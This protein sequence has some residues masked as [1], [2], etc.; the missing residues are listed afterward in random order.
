MRSAPTPEP[1]SD[2][3]LVVVPVAPDSSAATSASGSSNPAAACSLYNLSTGS[4]D[5][6][7]QLR[8]HPRFQLLRA[9]I[10]EPLPAAVEW[11]ARWGRAAPETALQRFSI[12]RFAAD[13]DRVLR[14]VVGRP[15]A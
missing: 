2:P 10:V 7:R 4:A 3:E 12:T 1:D 13:W 15:A 14:G 8:A 6:V 11:G 9:D 5:N